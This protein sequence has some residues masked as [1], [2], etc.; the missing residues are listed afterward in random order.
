MKNTITFLLIILIGK[1]LFA[2][3]FQNSTDTIKI[4]DFVNGG[5]VFKVDARGQHGLVCSKVDQAKG[6]H[7]NDEAAK[8]SDKNSGDSGGSEVKITSYDPQM[9]DANSS[10]NLATKVCDDYSVTESGAIYNDWYLPSK[11]E[12]QIIY[13]NKTV[14]DS[15][16]IAN[17]GTVF[18]SNNELS[19]TEYC[20][21]PAWDQEFNYG[22]KDY[23]Y[24]RSVLNVRA[25]R[26]F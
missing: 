5:I 8:I 4:G 6:I 7:W 24:K 3:E 18:E 11:D 2:Y 21:S 12:L 17:G 23:D 22:Y 25:I 1:S 13:L 9:K 14:I 10:D 15:S 16:A 19:P 26:I 20:N